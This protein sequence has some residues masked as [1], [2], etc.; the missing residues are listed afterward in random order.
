MESTC[1]SSPAFVSK[2]ILSWVCAVEV[3]EVSFSIGGSVSFALFKSLVAPVLSEGKG[4][5]E[6]EGEGKGNNV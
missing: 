1:P 3:T 6:G 2:S 5:G 4:E